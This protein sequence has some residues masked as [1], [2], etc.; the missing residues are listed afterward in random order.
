MQMIKNLLLSSALGL[1]LFSGAAPH[2]ASAKAAEEVKFYLT[3]S[4]STITGSTT[5][6]ARIKNGVSYLPANI[7]S[8]LG[9][10]MKWDMSGKRATF[11][12]WE[13]SF[14][15]R[16]GSPT[17]MLDNAT[18]PLGGTPFLEEDELFI[19]AKFLVKA[20]EGGTLRWD[21]QTRTLLANGLHLYRS[22]SESYKGSL[23]SVSLD[24]GDL[25]VSSGSNAKRTLVN[26]GTGLDLV[27]FKFEETP[28]GLTVLRISNSYGEPH[29]YAGYFTYI[30]KNGSLLRQT[31]TDFHSTFAEPA[32]WSEGKLLMNDGKTLRL[33]E[34]GTG[35]VSES[36]DLTKLMHADATQN[37]TYNVEGFYS[38][39]AL[40]RPRDTASLTLVDRTTG[41]QT[42]L[43]ERL[44]DADDRE[45]L[46]EQWD[47]MFPGDDLKFAGRSGNKLTIMAYNMGPE[48][49]EKKFIYTLPA[50]E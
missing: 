31:Y 2:D 29:L 28:G 33:I 44:L 8:G 20:L 48:R 38:D 34:D 40:I 4:N 25:S 14:A 22:Y 23:Y 47:S 39:I 36:I 5:G 27:D 16:L 21:P 7:V 12:G 11:S 6:T 18:V 1:F 37:P 30:L 41:T 15:V 10:E 50:A 24:T 32:L 13:K 26:L 3:Y 19:P 45:W 35:A 9:I 42:L 17:G 43:Y 49:E 46:L